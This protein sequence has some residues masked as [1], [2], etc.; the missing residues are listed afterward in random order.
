MTG[1]FFSWLLC[2]SLLPVTA[3]AADEKK[4][5]A[6]LPAIDRLF[7]DFQVDSHAPGLVYGGAGFCLAPLNTKPA[8]RE[9]EARLV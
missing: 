6:A 2:L 3:Q 7:A 8:L 1:R 4:I 5:E 9:L